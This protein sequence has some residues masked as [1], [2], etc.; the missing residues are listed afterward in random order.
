MCV[1]P[2]QNLA[3]LPQTCPL[4]LHSSCR[5]HLPLLPTPLTS[6]HGGGRQ[7]R[8]S[9]AVQPGL[10]Q[11][12]RNLVGQVVGLAVLGA[13]NQAVVV[14]HVLVLGLRGEAGGRGRGAGSEAASKELGG[15]W[16]VPISLQENVKRQQPG[17][18]SGPV[19]PTHPPHQPAPPPAGPPHRGQAR[20]GCLHRRADGAKRQ[21]PLHS[22]LNLRVATGVTG[23]RRGVEWLLE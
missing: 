16:A 17:L 12:R 23:S 18:P 2:T 1:L 7:A 15:G 3:H 8:A 10:L 13:G 20:L 21:Q 6:L 5:P 14:A 11:A 19:V 4:P 9:G 22:L